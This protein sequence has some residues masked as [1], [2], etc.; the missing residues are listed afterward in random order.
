MSYEIRAYK[1]EGEEYM[2]ENNLL[3]VCTRTLTVTEMLQIQG[4]PKDYVL[5]GTQTQAKKYI[6]NSV[7]VNVGIA[8]FKAIDA[9]IQENKKYLKV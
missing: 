2:Y 3:D 9:A 8:L 7:E 1:K 4:F 6:G 5:V